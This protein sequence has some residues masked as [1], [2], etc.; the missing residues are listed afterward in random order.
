[1]STTP[2]PDLARV[3]G[4]IA[5]PARAAMLDAML[6]GRAL[7]AG[8]L[9]RRAGVAPSTA[10]AHLARLV[11]GGMVVRRRH[12]RHHYYGLADSDVAEALEALARVS[13]PGT[14][15]AVGRTPAE[16]TLRFARTC[17]DHLAGRLGVAITDALRERGHIA[18]SDALVLTDSG[19]AWLEELGIDV[20]ALRRGRRPL[21]LA[22]LDWSERRI[23]LAGAAGAALAG[24][25][26][27]LGWLR[28][29]E[30]T[31]A[32]RLTLRGRDALSHSLGTEI[33]PAPGGRIADEVSRGQGIE[34][35]A[36]PG[37]PPAAP[38][39]EDRRARGPYRAC[40]SRN[41][42]EIR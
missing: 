27:E 32:V 10:S 29:L 13:R 3:A 34:C 8:E 26:L 9:A 25:L 21:A 31:R 36:T 18:G 15:D 2:G 11:A 12:G 42:F 33:P 24:R 17:Y 1:M 37:A 19:M 5:T 39:A 41:R 7:P 30:G 35:Y 16:R 38:V 14:G 4:M 40:T 28:R 22:C 6:G 20:A 23:H